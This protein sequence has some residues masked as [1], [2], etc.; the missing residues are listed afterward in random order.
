VNLCSTFYKIYFLQNI[1]FSDFFEGGLW[2]KLK[3]HFFANFTKKMNIKLFLLKFYKVKSI[4]WK[5][6]HDHKQSWKISQ[7]IRFFINTETT[8]IVT[9]QA[10]RRIHFSLYL[11]YIIIFLFFFR[12]N[13]CWHIVYLA[14]IILK[15]KNLFC[16]YLQ[17]KRKSKDIQIYYYFLV[18]ILRSF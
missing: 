16:L 10:Q 3:L 11:L 1:Y 8:Y 5:C 18:F 13:H 15:W 9:P 6:F 12:S 7:S 17:L 4:L 2:K 14:P